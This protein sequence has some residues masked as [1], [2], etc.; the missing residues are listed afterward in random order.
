MLRRLRRPALVLAPALL[1]VSLTACGEDEGPGTASGDELE[2]LEAVEVTGEVGEAIDVEWEGRMTATE[3]ETETLVEGD[4]EEVA[5]GDKILAHIWIGNGYTESEAYSTY[6]NGQP[7]TITVSDDL[8]PVFADAFEGQTLGSRVAVTASADEAFGEA[9]NPQLNIANKDSV[10]VVMDLVEEYEEP[11]PKDV[12]PGRLPNLRVGPDGP[13]GFDFSGVPKPEADGELLR[14]VLRE[15]K[16]KGVTQTSTIKANYLGMVHGAKKP[17]DESY[18]GQPAEF[19][20]T[21]VVPG[22][23][24]GLSGLKVGSRVLLSIPPDL[25]YGDQAQGDIPAG[26]TLYFVVDIISAK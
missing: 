8:S 5:T 23:T 4:G 12:P 22:W 24:Y 16:G 7:E 17:F 20:L 2:R 11:K 14:H 18:S 15:G 3:V 10:L 21:Q 26:S 13:V 25:G 9:G 19:S 1:A 6:E